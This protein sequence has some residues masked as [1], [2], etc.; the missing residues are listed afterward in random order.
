MSKT[1]TSG[2]DVDSV[3]RNMLITVTGLSYR[4]APLE[5]R[6]RMSIAEDQIPAA[7]RSLRGISPEGMILSTCNRFEIFRCGSEAS[8]SSIIPVQQLLAERSGLQPSAFEKSLYHYEGLDAVRHLFRVAASLDSM[9]VGEAQILG[10]LKR[11]YAL[12]QESEM[13]QSNLQSVIER[14]F[15][16]A[17][18]IRTQTTIS[19]KPVSISS[20]AVDLASQVFSDLSDKTV[21]VI[22]AGKMSL[23]SIQHLRSHGV[24]KLLITNRTF[25]KAA[26]MAEQT[27]GRAVLFQELDRCLEEADIVISSTGS[28]SFIVGRDQMQRAMARRK[29]KPVLLVDI[30]VPR[31]IDPDVNHIGNVFLYDI[32]DLSNVAAANKIERQKEAQKAEL[33][34]EQE[35]EIAWKKLKEQEVGP[36]IREIQQKIEQLCQ[37]ELDIS[38]RKF[39][40]ATQEQKLGM[41]RLAFSLAQKLLQGPFCELRQLAVEPDGSEKIQFIRRLF[42]A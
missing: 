16:V 35:A 30:A 41:E 37:H 6:E 2:N 27:G 4:T 15:S 36:T 33:I 8:D 21:F 25:Q 40:E 13:I 31:D 10:Q 1:R 3:N 5:I 32:D 28:P 20:V 23:L 22:G 7:L 12:A 19:A 34:V 9:V 14:A 17:K 29:N 39:G 38:M 24:T 11:A 42:L 26:E 18:K